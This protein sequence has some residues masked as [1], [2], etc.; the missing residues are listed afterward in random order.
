MLTDESN[1]L[2]HLE[3]VVSNLE[4]ITGQSFELVARVHGH[5]LEERKMQWER[6]SSIENRLAKLEDAIHDLEKRV[7]HIFPRLEGMP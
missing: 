4:K 1:K 2:L 6:I 3:N 7:I 5:S